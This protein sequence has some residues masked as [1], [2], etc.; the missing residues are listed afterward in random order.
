MR[1][2]TIIFICIPLICDA[3]IK[4]DKYYH[5]IAGGAISVG[6]YTVGQ[7]SNKEMFKYAPEM[8]G[9][10]AGFFKECY[11]GV[12]GKQFSY[13]DLLWTSVSAIITSQILKI[14]W[15]P[16]KKKKYIEFY[17]NKNNKLCQIQ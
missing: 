2:I 17:T 6:I 14:I 4:Q 12:N 7:N 15:K 3:Q 16:K 5:S 13:N 1:L 8:A 10:G 11:D 9:I